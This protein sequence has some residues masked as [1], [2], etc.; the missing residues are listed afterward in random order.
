LWRDRRWTWR[1]VVGFASGGRLHW[2]DRGATQAFGE[3]PH[4]VLL[5]PDGALELL[6]TGAELQD[7]REGDQDQYPEQKHQALT[8]RPP[9]TSTCTE[10]GQEKRYNRRLRNGFAAVAGTLVLLWD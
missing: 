1:R 6:H 7:E 8:F 9:S 3:I 5:A 10:G 4:F 2:R